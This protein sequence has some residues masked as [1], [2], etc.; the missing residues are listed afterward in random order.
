MRKITSQLLILITLTSCYFGANESGVHIIDDF[1]LIGWDQKD[2]QIVYSL[3]NKIYDP[4]K[5]IVQHD[6]FA[7]GN[8]KDFI[9]AKQ[10]PCENTSPHLIDFDNP[11]PNKTVTNYYIIKIMKGDN[12]Y[13]IHKFKNEN[14]FRKGK[15][16]LGV[17]NNLEYTFYDEKL[18]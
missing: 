6:V 7:V 12:N 5:I 4:E 9:I 11:K 14:D 16:N 2:W 10:H 8:N 3:D 18:E 15:I 17:P 13:Q 1:Y